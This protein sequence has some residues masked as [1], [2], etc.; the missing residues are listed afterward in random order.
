L[1]GHHYS[2]RALVLIKASFAQTH[3]ALT[4]YSLYAKMIP[5]IDRSDYTPADQMLWVEGGIWKFKLSSH[6]KF[7]T[8]SPEWIKFRVVSGHF[9]GMEGNIYFE[10]EGEKGTLVLLDAEQTAEEFPPKFIIEQGAQIVFGFTAK[11][12]RSYIEG[13]KNKEF[14]KNDE[15]NSTPRP[16]SHL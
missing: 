5:Y 16:R 6:L 3:D 2:V 14:E 13:L 15:S 4:D 11:R 10:P 9:A 1:E 7:E 8:K 12:M